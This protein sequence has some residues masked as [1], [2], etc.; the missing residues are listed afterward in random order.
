MQEN[1]GELK[2]RINHNYMSTAAI[3]RDDDDDYLYKEEVEIWVEDA[4]KEFPAWYQVGD[5]IYKYWELTEETRKIATIHGLDDVEVIAWFKKYF[6]GVTY[7]ATDFK[8]F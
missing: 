8:R 4:K 5:R 6:G 1:E 3:K 7:G 2:R